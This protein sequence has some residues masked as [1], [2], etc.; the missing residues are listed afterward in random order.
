MQ[1]RALVQGMFGGTVEQVGERA[2]HASYPHRF[3]TA[4]LM[5]PVV[6]FSIGAVLMVVGALLDGLWG[7]L[8]PASMGLVFS[9]VL[10][11][12]ARH[13]SRTMGDFALDV[14]GDRFERLSGDRVLDT[15]TMSNIVEVRRRWDFF[16][17]GFERAYWLTVRVDDGRVLRLGKGSAEELSVTLQLLA[18]WGLPVKHD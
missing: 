16:H 14:N 7:M 5:F 1:K 8:L 12:I 9:G 18:S 11:A 2:L 6:L 3:I 13:R 15:W 10:F 4:L 17:R